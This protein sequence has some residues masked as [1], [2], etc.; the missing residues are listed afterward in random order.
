MRRPSYEFS[1]FLNNGT[2]SH[3][4]VNV[5]MFRK[6]RSEKF[7]LRYYPTVY[8]PNS[9]NVLFDKYKYVVMLR[10]VLFAPNSRTPH[11]LED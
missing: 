10:N 7:I 1:V 8:T 2:T 11:E 9:I 3:V 4:R 5:P 6:I